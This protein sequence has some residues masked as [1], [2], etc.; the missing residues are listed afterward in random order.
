MKNALHGHPKWPKDKKDEVGMGPDIFPFDAFSPF[1][2]WP[3]LSRK[4]HKRHFPSR[5][6]FAHIK[7]GV[8]EPRHRFTRLL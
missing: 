8:L 2:Q 1:G 6:Q 5:G 4:G 7:E 3:Q